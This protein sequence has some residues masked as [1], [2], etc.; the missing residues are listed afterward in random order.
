MLAE[1]GKAPL[2][3]AR[4]STALSTPGVNTQAIR[5]SSLP[6]I[7]AVAITA[8]SHVD[9]IGLEEGRGRGAAR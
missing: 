3:L 9:E 7:P 1:G 5:A 6:A 8:P 4:V 2:E